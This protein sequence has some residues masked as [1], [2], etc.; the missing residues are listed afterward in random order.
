M[1]CHDDG[2][3]SIEW[4]K[5]N[6]E[7]V[8]IIKNYSKEQIMLQKEISGRNQFEWQETLPA[9]FFNRV[10]NSSNQTQYIFTL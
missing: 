6:V 8:Q 1:N 10:V 5:K 7:K 4:T 2:Q 9:P 3:G